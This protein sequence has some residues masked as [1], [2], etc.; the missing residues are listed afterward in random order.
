MS[1]SQSF[2]ALHVTV[3]RRADAK[4]FAQQAPATNAIPVRFVGQP[5][6]GNARLR[7]SRVGHLAYLPYR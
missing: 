3:G 2:L 1:A 5:S 7:P 4:G 6:D